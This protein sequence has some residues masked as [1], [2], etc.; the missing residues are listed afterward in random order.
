MPIPPIS[1]NPRANINSFD[2]NNFVAETFDDINRLS[3][4]AFPANPL[5]GTVKFGQ[6][7]SFSATVKGKIGSRYDKKHRMGDDGAAI[8]YSGA[9]S[10]RIA[11]TCV[12][13]T[14]GDV[15]SM[16]GLIQLG[17]ALAQGGK[18]L[19]VQYPGLQ[20][21]NTGAGPLHQLSLID[22]EIPTPPHDGECGHCELSF[23]QWIP[24]RAG[25]TK[26]IAPTVNQS[27]QLPQP[28]LGGGT[29][30]ELA[31]EPSPTTP[32]AGDIYGQ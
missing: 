18:A 26:P 30:L 27:E 7:Y 25:K 13:A 19:D 4:N 6:L 31:S 28:P 1:Q 14:S 20:M 11:I 24:A 21:F 5:W 17:F 10:E 22:A 16:Q 15:T 3:G 32:P 2:E 8:T 9:K 12:L 23:E 29:P